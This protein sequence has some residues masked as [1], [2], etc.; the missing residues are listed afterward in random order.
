M[1]PATGPKPARR[2]LGIWWKSSRDR[3]AASI[4]VEEL[5]G[6]TQAA[7]QDDRLR[8]DDRRDLCTHGTEPSTASAKHLSCN[9]IT[10]MH[11]VEDV[12]GSC[13]RVPA[14]LRIPLRAIDDAEAMCSIGPRNSPS[15]YIDGDLGESHLSRIA[16]GGDQPTARRGWL[17]RCPCRW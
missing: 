12:Q 4:S 13:D 7:S 1:S 10:G 6:P 3:S 15:A 9:R 17:P 11:G 2:I 14:A 5:I 8:C 16:A